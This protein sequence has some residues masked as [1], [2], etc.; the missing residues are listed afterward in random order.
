[1]DGIR[2]FPEKKNFLQTRR[3]VRAIAMC[4]LSPCCGS[5]D[6]RSHGFSRSESF[7]PQR[8]LC[9]YSGSADQ[10]G[11]VLGL[12]DGSP[13]RLA[14]AQVGLDCVALVLVEQ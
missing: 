3:S 6:F 11:A 7:Q 8:V 14:L 9:S 5:Q 1:M 10:S 12:E 2:C 4:E 13:R